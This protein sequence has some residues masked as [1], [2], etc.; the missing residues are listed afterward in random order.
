MDTLP[1][2]DGRTHV[3]MPRRSIQR[4]IAQRDE[5]SAKSGIRPVRPFPPRPVIRCDDLGEINILDIGHLLRGERIDEKVN[6]LEATPV[7]L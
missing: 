7:M 1:Q 2:D 3:D 6:R 5:Q 4:L